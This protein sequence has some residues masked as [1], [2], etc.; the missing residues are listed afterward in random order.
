MIFF[1]MQESMTEMKVN[2]PKKNITLMQYNYAGSIQQRFPY[3][4]PSALHPFQNTVRLQKFRFVLYQTTDN[5]SS[6][7]LRHILSIFLPS[8][9]SSFPSMP[10]AESPRPVCNRSDL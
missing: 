3:S 1:I 8:Q 5:E 2:F 9:L 10:R 7:G 4:L 6:C